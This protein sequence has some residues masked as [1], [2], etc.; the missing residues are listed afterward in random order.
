MPDLSAATDLEPI[1]K[2]NPLPGLP[3][4]STINTCLS[5]GLAL[6]QPLQLGLGCTSTF[7]HP[8]YS[9]L[10]LWWWREP[11]FLLKS[12]FPCTYGWGTP[13]LF[14]RPLPDQRD[15][16]QSLWGY[17]HP[18][19]AVLQGAPSQSIPHS[20]PVPCQTAHRSSVSIH[21]W[22]SSLMSSP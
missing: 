15:H 12:C 21:T 9:S 13:W 6:T 1:S 19:C 10:A 18:S 5:L 20:C 3:S 8:G 11:S 2:L 17:S 4:F 7:S 22:P 16:V 14:Q